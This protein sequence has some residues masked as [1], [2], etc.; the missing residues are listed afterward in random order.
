MKLYIFF[1]EKIKIK[2]EQN[3]CKDFML[4]DFKSI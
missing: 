2:G 1:G 3:S 4:K